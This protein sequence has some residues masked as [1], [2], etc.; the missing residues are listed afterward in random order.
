MLLFCVKLYRNNLLAVMI[1]TVRNFK[2]VALLKGGCTTMGIFS[3][4]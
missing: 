2:R 3:R 1:I 4:Y